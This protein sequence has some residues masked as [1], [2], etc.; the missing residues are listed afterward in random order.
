MQAQRPS[1]ERRGRNLGE[2]TTRPSRGSS[3]EPAD[4]PNDAPAWAS[5]RYLSSTVAPASSSWRLGL[6][7]V[8]L[9]DLLEHGLRRR[10]DQVLGL[11]QPEARERP[12]LLDDLDL[13]VAGRGED[14]VE[15]VLLLGRSGLA[16]PPPPPAAATATG[17]AAVTPNSSSNAFRNSF[18]S[19]TVMFLKMSSSSSVVGISVTLPRWVRSRL[20]QLRFGA[21]SVCLGRGRL[22]GG[23]FGS[24]GASRRRAR[25]LGARRGASASGALGLG[26]GGDLE[27]LAAVDPLVD[28]AP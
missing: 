3:T 25:R 10:V 27:G 8:F 21:V 24:A 14:D 1:A 18:S 16:A 12:D 22:G 28:R 5:L 9:G 20:L 13:L 7:G 4:A 2:D 19:R 17:A 11:L 26:L 6:L 23:G 15:L